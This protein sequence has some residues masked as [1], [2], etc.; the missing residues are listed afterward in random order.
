[1]ETFE[2]R[3]KRFCTAL[4]LLF[5]FNVSYSGRIRFEKWL[6]F[7]KPCTL[8][9]IFPCQVDYVCELAMK[10]GTSSISRYSSVQF[11][12][13]QLNLGTKIVCHCS[14]GRNKEGMERVPRKSM[15]A[16]DT[17]PLCFSSAR[18]WQKD[19]RWSPSHT[20]KCS[21]SNAPWNGSSHLKMSIDLT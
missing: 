14:L 17:H 1:M 10:I 5:L 12:L 19:E 9:I 3:M 11:C 6:N 13:D 15:D 18:L 4:I 8:S 21:W 7:A 16:S 20:P 2:H